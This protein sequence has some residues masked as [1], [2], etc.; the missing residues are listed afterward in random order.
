MLDH[1]NL[2]SIETAK[3]VSRTKT[4]RHSTKGTQKVAI[5]NNFNLRKDPFFQCSVNVEDQ[6]ERK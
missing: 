2:K 6:I 3:S 5:Q 4:E 1:G